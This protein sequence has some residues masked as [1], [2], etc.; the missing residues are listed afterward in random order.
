MIYPDEV[1]TRE[2][3]T[4]YIMD[5]YGISEEN[6]PLFKEFVNDISKN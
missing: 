4:Q 6:S 5:V 2:E 3:K 1:N